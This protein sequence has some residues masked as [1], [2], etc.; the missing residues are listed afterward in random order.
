[1]NCYLASCAS[2][3]ECSQ[4]LWG[5]A[6]GLASLS[7]VWASGKS[8]PVASQAEALSVVWLLAELQAGE[9]WANGALWWPSL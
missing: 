6:I 5:P 9:T 1:M 2:W 4:A 7:P 3:A 8:G